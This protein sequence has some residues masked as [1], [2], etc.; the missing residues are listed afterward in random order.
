MWYAPFWIFFSVIAIST[1]IILAIRRPRFVDFQVYIMVWA[2]TMSLDMLF[3]KELRLYSYVN[4][5]HKGWYSL[6][7]N[8]VILPCWGLL[9]SMFR[10]KTTKAAVFY[11]AGW[12]IASTMAELFIVQPLGIVIYPVWRIIPYSLLGYIP[13]LTLIYIY[14]KYLEKRIKR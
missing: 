7:A 13:V 6:W 3:C 5:L 1:L 8:S 2:L 14:S 12:T 10:S 4:I 11:I 9:F